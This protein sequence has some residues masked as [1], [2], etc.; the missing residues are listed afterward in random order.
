VKNIEK[1]KKSDPGFAGSYQNLATYYAARGDYPK[2]IEQLG[3]LQAIDQKNARALLGLAALYEISGKD[4]EALAQYQKATREK[5][6]EAFLAQAGYHQKKGETDK[7]IK[8]LDEAIKLD[9]RAAAPLEMKGRLLVAARKYRDA[10]KVFEEIEALNQ[11]AG[12]ALKI[13]TYVA[14]Q[15][16]PKAVE[17][18]RRLIAKRPSSASGYLVL[19]SVYQSQK[20]LTSA[21]SEV[22]NGIR[23]D[24]KSVEARIRLGNLFEGRKEFDKAMSAYRDAL[25]I[26]PDSA[27]ALFSQGALLDRTGKKKEAIGKY[28]A[29]LEKTDGFVPAL[30]NLAYLCA[31]GYGDKGEAL[32]LAISA[33]KREPGN[34]GIMDTVGYALLKNGRKA[35]AVKVLERAVTQLPKDP[36]VRYHLAL[37]YKESGDKA[38]AELSLKKSLE[39]GEGPDA[40]A[41]RAL[42]A[43]LKR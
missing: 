10:L 23:V 29:V 14:M 22:S 7:A 37:A 39:L 33:F 32:R 42:L 15:E 6:P 43:E 27:A 36:T 16:T 28:R 5:I 9:P 2:A 3:A 1:A 12:V 4:S 8:V 24:A 40:T 25:S 18:A 11:D 34:A 41:V 31:D 21:I 19:A 30:N 20:D 38:K 35:D 26:A 13:A 17:Q